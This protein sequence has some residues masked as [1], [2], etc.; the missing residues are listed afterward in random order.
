MNKKLFSWKA[1]AGLALLVAM[2]LTSCKQ[3]NAVKFDENGN[4]VIPEKP[5]TPTAT[6][7]S[8]KGFKTVAELNTLI[9]G[10]KDITDNIKAGGSV[11]INLDCSNLEAAAGDKIVIPG[12]TDATINLV[13]T[14]KAKKNDGLVI[15]DDALD[16]VTVTF[17]EGEFGDVAFEMP[18]STLT[19]AS[20]GATTL[21]KTAFNVNKN[22]RSEF[23][24]TIS[25]GI[26]INSIKT[27]YKDANDVFQWSGRILAKEGAK[28]VALLIDADRDNVSNSEKGYYIPQ[29]TTNLSK[30]EDVYVKD[31]NVVAN[32]VS[33]WADSYDNKVVVNKITIA[34]GD[35]VTIRNAQANEIVGAGKG[36]VLTRYYNG[37][38][39][40][41]SNLTIQ[42]RNNG[43]SDVKSTFDNCTLNNFN[44][45][46]LNQTTA[47]K[48][49]FTQDDGNYTAVYFPVTAGAGDAT[50]KY[51]F[52]E[53][54]F[55][56]N[57]NVYAYAE[58]TNVL[59][60]NGNPIKETL[61]AYQ[62]VDADGNYQYVN[63]IEKLTDIPDSIRM[64]T[65]K[66]YSN[67]WTYTY[68]PKVYEFSDLSIIPSFAK[69]KYD[70]KD[71]SDKNIFNFVS[72]NSLS[73]KDGKA[74]ATTT[75]VEIDGKLYKRIWTK[76][77]GYILLEQ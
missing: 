77:N 72:F 50:F 59:D 73:G 2:G 48:L 47:S 4:Y 63:G 37:S 66:N 42:G 57:L 39:A 34:E 44:S 67:F 43:Y 29:V 23:A 53:C 36:A 35:T 71:V 10:T 21:G 40:K 38:P 17:P 20:A 5:V 70:G 6:G 8:L 13:F 54:E 25:S 49:K 3:D 64:N 11:T 56:K 60:K 75:E 61:Y 12:K 9:A 41:Y 62:Y 28:I 27:W 26:T 16:V 18:Y 31:L 1:L 45:L 14:N 65:T 32:N 46:Y 51:S 15:A 52:S 30:W 74:V 7:T 19:L 76:T 24:T 69:C 68:E 22:D 33:V 55:A 58:G